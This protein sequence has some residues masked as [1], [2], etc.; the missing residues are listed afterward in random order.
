MC[1]SEQDGSKASRCQISCVAFGKSL[2]STISNFPFIL[3]FLFLVPNWR[4]LNQV[5]SFHS[6][7]LD[8]RWSVYPMFS[9]PK[10]AKSKTK[11]HSGKCWGFYP[12]LHSLT[13]NRMVTSSFLI[14]LP[15]NAMPYCVLIFVGQ[16]DI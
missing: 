3:D 5:Q 2:I 8:L 16:R 15:R 14:M 11:E 6:F 1:F 4:L 9:I 7:Q 13:Y 12:Y 10:I